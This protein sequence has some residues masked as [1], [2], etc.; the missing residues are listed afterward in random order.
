[1]TLRVKL[2]M[3]NMYSTDERDNSRICKECQEL[4]YPEQNSPFYVNICEDC[5]SDE[6]LYEEA[7][8]DCDCPY[9][10]GEMEI[11]NYN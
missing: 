6:D 5:R 9:C 2:I 10:T 11:T 4:F 3:G 8:G 7:E 1:M